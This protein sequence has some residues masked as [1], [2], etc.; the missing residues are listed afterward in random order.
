MKELTPAQIL[1][2]KYAGNIGMCFGIS[3]A[4]I[5]LFLK[6]FWYIIPV[7]VISLFLQ[8]L[9]LIESKR[10]WNQACVFQDQ[11]V[12]QQLIMADMLRE[13]IPEVKEDEKI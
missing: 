1:Y 6:G 10:A 4:G 3:F 11:M 8:V 9:S 13:I 7:L 2:A 12:K 5:V